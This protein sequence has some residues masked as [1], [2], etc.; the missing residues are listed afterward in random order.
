[1]AFNNWHIKIHR[2]I[3]IRQIIVI[4]ALVLLITLSCVVGVK[5]GNSVVAKETKDNITKKKEEKKKE[6]K[7]IKVDVKGAVATPGVYELPKGSR[8][9]DAIN[10]AGGLAE[11]ANTTI[12]NLSKVLED[13]FVVVVYTDNDLIDVVMDKYVK[14]NYACPSTINDA[15]IVDSE[16]SSVTFTNTNKTS[17]STSNTSKKEN[18]NTNSKQSSGIVNL[19]SAT[20]EELQT[21]P[22]IGE[23]KAKAIIQYREENGG[24]KSVDELTNV[25]GIGES[26]LEKIKANITI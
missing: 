17:N 14:N 3:Q 22:G 20:V 15:C 13:G 8:V 26:T 19:N 24:F 10:I 18:N 11:G 21:L 1:M 2:K 16:N 5:S 23:S 6:V 25:S 7:N 9:I 4:M 12:I